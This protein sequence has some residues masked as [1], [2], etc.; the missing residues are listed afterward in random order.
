MGKNITIKQ[1]GTAENF[2]GVQ[3]IEIPSMDSGSTEWVPEEGGSNEI[4][5]ITENGT[6]LASSDGVAGWKVVFVNVPP[7]QIT[8]T[9]PTDGQNY[10]YFVDGFG[11]LIKIPAT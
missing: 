1:N 5:Q 2:T 8:G 9:D 3:H 7:T 11:N 10:T 6:Y 4:K